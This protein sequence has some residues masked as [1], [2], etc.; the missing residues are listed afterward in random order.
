MSQ[1]NKYILHDKCRRNKYNLFCTT[2]LRLENKDHP[3]F[4]FRYN[5]TLRNNVLT[6]LFLH[7]KP[8]AINKPYSGPP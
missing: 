3:L 6:K 4:L 7:D 8:M 1:K 5:N 2:I